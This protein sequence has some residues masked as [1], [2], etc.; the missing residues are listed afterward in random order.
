MSRSPTRAP[1][2][3]VFAPTFEEPAK[4][5]FR[6]EVE[7]VAKPGRH[8]GEWLRSLERAAFPTMGK[9]P[10]NLID[11]ADVLKVLSPIWHETP[12]TARR[13]RR[14]I[15]QVLEWARAA[16]HRSGENPVDR[17]KPGAGLAKQRDKVKHFAALPYDELPVLWPRLL[18]VE[19][20]GAAALRFAIL[21]AARSGEVRGATWD[22]TPC[23]A[24]LPW[25]IAV[26][27]RTPGNWQPSSDCRY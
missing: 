21:T 5:V 25:S 8:V 26:R 27:G 19:G 20:M 14:R 15:A 3:G 2:R 16:G 9:T 12:E 22:E 10:V 24:S 7:P 18:A 4:T 17:V 11:E 1:R 13:I 23:G 6:E